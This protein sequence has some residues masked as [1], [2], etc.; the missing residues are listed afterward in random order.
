MEDIASSQRKQP[1]ERLGLYIPF[2]SDTPVLYLTLRRQ[3]E[4]V[5]II[6]SPIRSGYVPGQP[7]GVHLV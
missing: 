5:S 2:L 7:A 1:A 6:D 3:A 4:C